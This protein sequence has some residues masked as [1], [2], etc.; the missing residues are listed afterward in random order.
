MWMLS[1]LPDDVIED[2]FSGAT[3]GL[4]CAGRVIRAG[5]VGAP[6]A[7]GRSGLRPGLVGVFHPCHGPGGA[8]RKTARRD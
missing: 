8:G 6:S 3:L 4:E 7:A 2:G 5:R 1:L